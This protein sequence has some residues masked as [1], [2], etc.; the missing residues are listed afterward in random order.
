MSLSGGVGGEVEEHKRRQRRRAGLGGA[1]SAASETS[2]TPRPR[3]S[4]STVEY[5]RTRKPPVRRWRCHA[6]MHAT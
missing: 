1:P 6:T 2:Q 3:E 4:R 5:G